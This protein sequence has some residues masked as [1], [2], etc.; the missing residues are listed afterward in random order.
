MRKLS[1][2]P[3]LFMIMVA[4]TELTAQSANALP[5][6]ISMNATLVNDNKVAIEWTL[7]AR[8]TTEEYDVEKSNDGISW[9][10]VC[11]VKCDSSLTLPFTYRSM[12]MFPLKGINFYRVRL[13]DYNGRLSVT[14]VKTVR[15][16]AACDVVVYPNPAIDIVRVLPGQAPVTDWYISI[17]N[18]K[19]QVILQK[20]YSKNI[21]GVE[22]PVNNIPGGIYL[23]EVSNG[24]LKQ[25][26]RLLINHN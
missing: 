22:L 4:S 7:F 24:N 5:V 19:G 10:S 20:K 9:K 2:L 26:K 16:N 14:P 18:S 25:V 12:D 21:A 6:T 13:K 11:T 15:V 23:L 8:L 1:F 3:I 17:I